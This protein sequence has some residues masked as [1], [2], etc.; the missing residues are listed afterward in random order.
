MKL[1]LRK[2]S[3]VL[4]I[5]MT[6]GL[7]IPPPFLTSNA[8]E[9]KET[10]DSKTDVN[11]TL[12]TMEVEEVD[13]SVNDGYLE[14]DDYTSVITAKAREQMITKLGPKILNQ[15]EDDLMSTILPNTEDVLAL[16]LAEAGEEDSIYF[17][18]TEHPTTGYGEK[19]FTIY[20]YRTTQEIARFDVR[21]DNRPDD[22]YWF[23]FHYHLSKDNFE[24]HYEIGEIYWDKNTPPKWMA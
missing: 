24:K 18:I 11:E 8:K 14:N 4:I 9:D 1:W 3:A 16:I 2:I 15:V 22:G 10:L 13:D 21:R 5:I 23:N 6:L 7:Y 12:L 20:D 19:I 17:E